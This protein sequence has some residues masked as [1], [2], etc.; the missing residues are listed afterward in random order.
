MLKSVISFVLNKKQVC[1]A[2][3][4]RREGAETG[5]VGGE[6]M[7]VCVCMW[8]GFASHIYFTSPGK[9]K[10]KELRINP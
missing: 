9:E 1:E 3:A 2:V 8:G 4:A 6:G 10:K 5:G 7:S